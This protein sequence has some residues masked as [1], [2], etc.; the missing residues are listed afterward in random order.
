MTVRISVP[1]GLLL[2]ALLTACDGPGTGRAITVER[3]SAAIVI[4]ENRGPYEQWRVAPEPELRIGTVEG[5]SA[6]QFHRV[7]FAG[8]MSD[9]RVVVADAGSGEIRW[10][11][12]AGDHRSTVGRKGGGPEEFRGIGS[13]LLTPADTLVVHDPG[14]GRLTWI[15]P[16]ETV[17]RAATLDGIPSGS[18][19]LLGRAP[20]NDLAL[21][22]SSPAYDVRRP[23]LNYTRDTLRVLVYA[24][25]KIDTIA[26]IPGTEGVLWVRFAGGQ[27]VARQHMDMPFPHHTLAAVTGEGFALAIGERHEVE[28][29]EWNGTLRRVA[30]RPEVAGIPITEDDRRRYVDHAVQSAIDRGARNPGEAEKNAN[31]FLAVVPEGHSVPSFS[32]LL[33]ESGGRIWLRDFVPPW[34]EDQTQSWTVYRPDGHVAGVVSVPSELDVMQVGAAYVTGVMRDSL[35]V[36][37][38]VVHRIER[39]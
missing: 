8:R 25:E 21:A 9:G 22:V 6:Y 1:S 23:D 33:V 18:V 4:I 38:V 13:V 34:V 35:D 3:D 20:D 17:V 24:S 10:F 19:T 14:N 37:Y 36:E 39:R 5:D 31:A 26:R 7:V 2:S 27:P 32:E 30:R 16:D 28:V 12:P 11:G 29:H 15:A